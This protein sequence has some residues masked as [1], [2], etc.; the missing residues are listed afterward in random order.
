MGYDRVFWVLLSF[1]TDRTSD[2]IGFTDLFSDCVC[3]VSY[4]IND[5]LIC[6][7]VSFFKS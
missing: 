6:L 4:S 3:F 1:K 2:D 5:L 7:F